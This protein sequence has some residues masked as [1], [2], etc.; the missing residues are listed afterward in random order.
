M[1]ND[2]RII[3][4]LKKGDR[5]IFEDLYREY[6]VPL[7]YYCVRYVERIEDAEELVQ[8]IFVKLWDKHEEI[9]INSSIGAYLH[10]AVQNY[11]L[12]FLNKRKVKDKYMLVQDKAD[13]N[14][15][16][17]GLFKLEQEELRVV[18][19]KAILELPEKR[20]RI[21]EL[22]RYD[23]LKNSLIAKQLSIS[24]KTV[25]SQMTKALK[26]LRV[27]LK[28]HVPIIAISLIT[29]RFIDFFRL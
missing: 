29:Y 15:I 9:D 10:R 21:F 17:D 1:E 3:E 28:D 8:D 20:R 25:E 7:C 4:G 2:D 12:N 22:S 27:V 14:T 23:G 6:Y 18:L 5:A 26:Y 13:F 16:D 19:K 11:A 24:V